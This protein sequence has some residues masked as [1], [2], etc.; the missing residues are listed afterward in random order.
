MLN[1]LRVCIRKKL[2]IDVGVVCKSVAT[3]LTSDHER[4]DF[5]ARLHRF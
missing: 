3:K 1:P 5:S 4:G 2:S